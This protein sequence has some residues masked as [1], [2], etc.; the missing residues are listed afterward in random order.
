MKTIFTII[1]LAFITFM[2]NGQ[3]YVLFEDYFVNTTLRI[4]YHH[5]G[6]AQIELFTIDK[7]YE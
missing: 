1:F 3:S 7:I 2:L 4:D 6:D 5:I